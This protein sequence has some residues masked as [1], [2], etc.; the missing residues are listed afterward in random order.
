MTKTG[1]L[2][3]YSQLKEHDK[4]K[5]LMIQ[6]VEGKNL[7]DYKKFI[8]DPV[9]IEFEPD[10]KAREADPEQ[11][12]G[13]RQYFQEQLKEQLGKNYTIVEKPSLDVL[14]LRTAITDIV[15]S[16][17]YF[18]IHWA[19]KL[20]RLGLGGASLEAELLDSLTNERVAAVIYSRQ[21]RGITKYLKGFSKWGYT[22]DSLLL[23]AEIFTKHLNDRQ[24]FKGK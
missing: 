22:K 14:R 12:E 3:D 7:A 17:P 5:C 10:S 11:V 6:E 1:Y 19:T 13:I 4:Y 20:S 21:G 23:W 9:D 2:G 15:A 8:I 16:K 18:N 24:G